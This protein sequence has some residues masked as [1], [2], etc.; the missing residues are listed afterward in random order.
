[1]F[2]SCF[3]VFAAL[4]AAY[5]HYVRIPGFA[6]LNRE[7]LHHV[8]IMTTMKGI[9]PLPPER[10]SG[11]LSHYATQPDWSIYCPLKLMTRSNQ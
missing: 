11:T 10:Q 5:P 8:L 4:R 1:M 9:E 2:K 6:M 7:L 3:A